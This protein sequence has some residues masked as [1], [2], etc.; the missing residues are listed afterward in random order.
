MKQSEFEPLIQYVKNWN[1]IDGLKPNNEPEFINEFIKLIANYPD[2]REVEFDGE[3]AYF[4]K[5]V[6][7]RPFSY[8][9]KGPRELEFEMAY[10]PDYI[11]IYTANH[12]GF[13]N[14]EYV[15]VDRKM[16]T[17]FYEIYPVLMTFLKGAF[18]I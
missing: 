18:G 10:S 8:Y 13:W 7:L 15:K 12:H 11:S 9:G 5:Q 1:S 6:T 16:H 2:D 3:G 17:A 14:P 4:G